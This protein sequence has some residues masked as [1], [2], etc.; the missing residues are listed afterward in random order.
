MHEHVR[1]L[2][3][4][5]ILRN[6]LLREAT[7]TLELLSS[8]HETRREAAV[9]WAEPPT[10]SHD[11]IDPR[12]STDVSTRCGLPPAQC[13]T[14]PTVFKQGHLTIPQDAA[15][16]DPGEHLERSAQ[17]ISERYRRGMHTLIRQTLLS[18]RPPLSDRDPSGN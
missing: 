9:Y 15:L 4:D 17:S 6:A 14:L 5:A 12:S 18:G 2:T 13:E 16:T 10:S 3:S 1:L 7:W 8:A 11:S